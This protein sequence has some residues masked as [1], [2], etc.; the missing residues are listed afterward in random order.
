MQDRS[1]FGEIVTRFTSNAE[2]IATEA[3]CYVLRTYPSAWESTRRL[4]EKSGVSFDEHLAFSTQASTVSE[5]RPDLIG[6]DSSGDR[7][8]VL[9]AK[10]WA[11]LTPNQP[12]SYLQLL[13]PGK[14]SMV[15]VVAP[16]LRQ[17]TLWAKLRQITE[18]AGI[19]CSESIEAAREFRI[20]KINDRH[21]LALI[22]WRTILAEIERDA[23]VA[24]LASLKSDV[25]QLSGLCS[26]MDGESF[27]PLSND[28]LAPNL[29]R[30]IRQFAELIEDAV[31]I[32]I[33]EHGDD[34]KHVTS[35]GRR[36]SYGV[37]FT[38]YGYGMFLCFHPKNWSQNAET[39]I[40]VNVKLADRPSNWPVSRKVNEALQAAFAGTP[41][42]VFIGEGDV[43]WIPIHL[44]VG[45][46]RS[47]VLESIV[48]QVKEVAAAARQSG[49]MPRATLS[50]T[51]VS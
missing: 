1:V 29:G 51:G 8:L 49:E 30:R 24:G 31:R 13:P 50:E 26:K 32:L 11:G 5:G 45:C 38:I 16:A 28:D 46:E 42:E 41:K 25:T 36:V 21:Q 15:L 20:C 7:V 35:S 12:V 14:P 39:P 43:P 22:S 23:D 27:L 18:Q 2:D 33:E 34:A 10:F 19:R 44:P 4:L 37:F 47:E 48:E 3:L 17:H 6:T 9:E 40:W